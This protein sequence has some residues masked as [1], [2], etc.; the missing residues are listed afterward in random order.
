M[1]RYSRSRLPAGRRRKGFDSDDEEWNR[2]AGVL[3]D[4]PQLKGAPYLN[5]GTRIFPEDLEAWEKKA[6]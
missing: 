5:P 6:E 3:Y 1:E 4:I 2:H